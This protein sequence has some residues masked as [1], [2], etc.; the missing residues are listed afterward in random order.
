MRPLS[1]VAVLFLLTN[2]S[3]DLTPGRRK[4]RLREFPTRLI[5]DLPKLNVL[6]ADRT[7]TIEMLP[8]HPRLAS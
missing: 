4:T 7:T 6:A 1:R 5:A 2:L 3:F 8:R